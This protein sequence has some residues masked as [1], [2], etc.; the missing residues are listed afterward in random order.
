MAYTGYYAYEG[1]NCTP[2]PAYTFDPCLATEHARVRAVALL[3]PGFY[4]VDPTSLTEWNNAI[5]AGNVILLPE[6]RGKFD[7]GSAKK[8]E[9][10]GAQKERTL[11]YDFQLD[12]KDLAMYPNAVFYDTIDKVQNWQLAY[13]TETLLWLVYSPVDISVK[14]AVTENIEDEVV[15]EVMITWQSKSHP[16]KF[17]K[18]AGLLPGF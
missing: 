12:F 18:P 7:G 17:V 10:Y 15:E 16:Q 2:P 1:G 5:A 8:G 13:F 6:T 4:F 11:F 9:G 3:A 14:D